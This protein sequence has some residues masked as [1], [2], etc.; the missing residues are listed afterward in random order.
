M[1]ASV[2][3]VCGAELSWTLRGALG[4]WGWVGIGGGGGEG[5]YRWGWGMMKK[6]EGGKT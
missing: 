4:G 5:G 2:S 1:Y 3:R 6:K